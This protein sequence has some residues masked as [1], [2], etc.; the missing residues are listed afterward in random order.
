MNLHDDDYNFEVEKRLNGEI[1][2]C[3]VIVN[4]RW[5]MIVED[6]HVHD[7][8]NKMLAKVKK[9]TMIVVNLKKMESYNCCTTYNMLSKYHHCNLLTVPHLRGNITNWMYKLLVIFEMCM[10]LDGEWL[11]DILMMM[12]IKLII[13]NLYD[14]Q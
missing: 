6:V 13:V 3:N 4:E 8:D 14:Q 12:L 2:V 7:D 9:G 10:F 5:A 11:V 1:G